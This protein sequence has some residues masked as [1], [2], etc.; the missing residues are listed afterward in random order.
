MNMAEAVLIYVRLMGE[1]TECFRP[2]RG[3]EVASGL[4]KLL[5]SPNYDSD[6]EQWEFPPGSVVRTEQRTSGNA[7]ILVAIR[8]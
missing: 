7:T 3:F 5:P 1:G 4:F 8:A 2:A 6:D